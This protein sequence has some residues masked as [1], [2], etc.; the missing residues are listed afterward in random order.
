MFNSSFDDSHV[1]FT[2]LENPFRGFSW[3]CPMAD[4]TVTGNILSYSLFINLYVSI[5]L[6]TFLFCSFSL[7]LVNF[8]MVSRSNISF[9][10]SI[11]C[12]AHSLFCVVFLSLHLLL[13][14]QNKFHCL[15]CL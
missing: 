14:R 2:I 5:L 7:P 11:R 4:I 3:F 10:V 13:L 8:L 1:L 12:T 9:A 6:K 15:I